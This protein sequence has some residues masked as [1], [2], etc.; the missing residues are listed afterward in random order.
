MR[1]KYN[2]ARRS[3]IPFIG[4]GPSIPLGLPSWPKLV[5]DYA[6]HVDYPHNVETQ[7]EK[8]NRSW[9]EVAEDIY[10]YSGA[11]L[12][13]Y[14][15]HMA[16]MH[17]TESEWTSFHFLL[18]G[19][20]KRIITTNYDYALENAYREFHRQSG[21]IEPNCLYFPATLDAMNFSPGSIAYLH[22]QIRVRDFVFRDS[23][24]K[25]AYK[26]HTI[27]ADFL[28]PVSKLH[29]LLFIG[30]SFDDPIFREAIEKIFHNRNQELAEINLK[31]GA[32][33]KIDP[34]K[35]YTFLSKKDIETTLTQKS[36]TTFGVGPAAQA[37]YF[38]EQIDGTFELV[39]EADIEKE[40]F[41]LHEDFKKE[42]ERIT[43]NAVR[44]NY[45]NALE[46]GILL[47]DS[48]NRLEISTKI[49][50]IC[51]PETM[52]SDNLPNISTTI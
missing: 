46:F 5:A 20:F 25:F 10:I 8:F 7:F 48:K 35:S 41:F 17:P 15:N 39:W 22:G 27:I 18:V 13:A 36:L 37:K 11:D 51:Q 12:E 30:F 38:S 47:Y 3:I 52:A 23:E 14:R 19:N 6:A 40:P 42:Y 24:Y 34:P 43:F 50:Q 44:L 9:S 1:A 29:Y 4:A 26:E 33:H 21:N 16:E 32:D 31:F 49:K 45:L 2:E 28:K